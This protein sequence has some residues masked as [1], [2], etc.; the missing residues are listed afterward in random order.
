MVGVGASSFLIFG[1]VHDEYTSDSLVSDFLDDVHLCNCTTASWEQVALPKAG[2][3]ARMGACLAYRNGLLL[4][5]GK[6]DKDEREVTLDDL[7]IL[8]GRDEAAGP[9]HP[10]HDADIASRA[11][12]PAAGPQP[13]VR[14]AARALLGLSPACAAWFP[15]SDDGGA[16][17]ESGSGSE[18]GSDDDDNTLQAYRRSRPR[19]ARRRHVRL[20]SPTTSQE[21]WGDEDWPDPAGL[22]D[23][24]SSSEEGT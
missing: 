22:S 7:W 21:G 17:D 1:G 14:M 9:A 5:G 15:D 12:P 24:S 8:H 19:G 2:P 18:S 3:Q 6:T 23:C 16:T 20:S 13:A 11:P 4:F 10:P